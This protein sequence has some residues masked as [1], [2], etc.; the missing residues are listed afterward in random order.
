[1]KKYALVI[2]SLLLLSSCVFFMVP[3]DT[4][5]DFIRC[6]SIKNSNTELDNKIEIEGIYF[7][8]KSKGRN[9]SLEE[10]ESFLPCFIFYENGFCTK[11][12]PYVWFLDVNNEDVPSSYFNHGSIWGL[13]EIIG[14]TIKAH[15]IPKPGAMDCRVEKRSFNI[16]NDTCLEE[17]IFNGTIIHNSNDNNMYFIFHHFD[18]LPNPKKSWIIKKKWFWCNKSEYKRWK[19]ESR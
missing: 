13:Y 16:K 5:D 17:T 4:K 18:S 15:F 8:E 3:R 9:P 12:P 11:N 6:Y 1:M 2:I 7:P 10:L 19:K 14:D